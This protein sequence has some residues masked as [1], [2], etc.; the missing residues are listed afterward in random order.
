M[1]ML[2]ALSSIRSQLYN[3]SRETILPTTPHRCQN[4]G[5]LIVPVLS[6]R[7]PVSGVELVL[8][9]CPALRDSNVKCRNEALKT[10]TV[11]YI[12]KLLCAAGY[13]V[14][15]II[16]AKLSW[17]KRRLETDIRYCTEASEKKG[18]AWGKKSQNWKNL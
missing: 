16:G 18:R 7:S 13:L 5:D 4:T 2:S 6:L 3:L 17:Q 9:S 14:I 1:F 8:L 15:E 12:M 11:T 10:N